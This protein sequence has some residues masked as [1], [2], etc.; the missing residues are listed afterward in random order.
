MHLRKL[1]ERLTTNSISLELEREV[2]RMRAE[3]TRLRAENRALLNS[4]LGIAGIPPIIVHTPE[5]ALMNDVAPANVPRDS[6]VNAL[7]AASSDPFP[8]LTRPDKPA[9]PKPE[10]VI[11]SRGPRLVGTRRNL[12]HNGTQLNSSPPRRRSWQQINRML[13][14]E[15]ARKKPQEI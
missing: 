8:A 13:E 15:S 14:L 3:N 5:E 7:N 10:S 1:W 2:A 11:P 4:I 12:R 9:N 6:S